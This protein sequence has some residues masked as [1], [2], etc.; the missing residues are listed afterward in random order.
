MRPLAAST[1]TLLLTLS[2]AFT[3]GAQTPPPPA[4]RLPPAGI[5]I[6]AYDRTE[7]T[8]A[9]AALATDHCLRSLR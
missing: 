6:P 9:T 2:F 8:T 5:A 4:K 7:L 3:S 1:L